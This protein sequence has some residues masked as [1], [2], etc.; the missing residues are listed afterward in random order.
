MHRYVIT[1]CALSGFQV[2]TLPLQKAGDFRLVTSPLDEAEL[3]VLLD[4]LRDLGC[5]DAGAVPYAE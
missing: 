1:G 4:R 5:P 2:I 3:E